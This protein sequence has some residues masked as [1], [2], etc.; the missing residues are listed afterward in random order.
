MY[1]FLKECSNSFNSQSF[2]ARSDVGWL[3]LV[4]LL[5]FFLAVYL[6][7]VKPALEQG[8]QIA[9]ARMNTV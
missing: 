1:I 7:V 3:R 4:S 6:H 2:R 9:I 8:F 5:Q